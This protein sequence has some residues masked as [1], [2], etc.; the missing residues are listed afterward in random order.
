MRWVTIWD[1]IVT[2]LLR[3]GL[4]SL[5]AV[6]LALLMGV[7]N[8]SSF[9]H[10]ELYMIGAYAGWFAHVILG[11]DPIPSILFAAVSSFV[12]GVLIEKAFFYPL[13]RR[14]KEGWLLNAYLVTVGLSFVL[15]NVAL[16]AFKPIYRGIK[17][18]WKGSI[19]VSST[20]A[21]STDRIIGF[22]FA[23]ATIVAFW[24]FLRRT[25]MGWAIRAVAQDERGAMLVGISLDRIYALSFGLS[26]MLAGIA[27]AALLSIIPAYPTMGS[28][29]LAKSWFVVILAGLGNIRGAIIGG[30]LVGMMEAVSYYFIGG[31]WQDAISVLIVVIILLLKP[32]GLFG[33]EVKGILER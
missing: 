19:A 9:M 23:I 30:F 11:L 33:T 32:S 5:M 14:S 24:F 17:T 13:R 1:L 22:L 6:G 8:I 18:Y 25:K 3:G 16:A 12:A 7:T 2:G 26:S 21:I 28:L 15:Q 4:Y 27:G 31:G 10:G 29:P 20:M